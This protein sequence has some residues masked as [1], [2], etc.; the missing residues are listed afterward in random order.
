MADIGLTSVE[1]APDAEAAGGVL[2]DPGEMPLEPAL[3]TPPDA[4]AASPS[5]RVRAAAARIP[6]RMAV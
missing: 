3:G 6:E 2:G 5:D 4:Q 1:G